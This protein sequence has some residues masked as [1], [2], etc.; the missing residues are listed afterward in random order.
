MT[1]QSKKPQQKPKLKKRTNPKKS[2][3]QSEK[4]LTIRQAWTIL[5]YVRVIFWV[6]VI[7][8]V[9][10][11]FYYEIIQISITFEQTEQTHILFSF[12]NGTIMGLYLVLL[13]LGGNKL[14]TWTRFLLIF[15]VCLFVFLEIGMIGFKIYLHLPL[16]EE[17]FYQTNS[18]QG[19]WFL[20]RNW[21]VLGT[22]LAASFLVEVD[23]E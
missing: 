8:G 7:V 6:L 15:I 17:P 11:L 1:T 10:L 2:Q 3:G 14:P 12:L 13:G 21:K 20:Y 4:A 9:F 16:I 23:S 5:D 18:S 19:A 22:C